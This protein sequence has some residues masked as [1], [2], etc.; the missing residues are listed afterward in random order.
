MQLLCPFGEISCIAKISLFDVAVKCSPRKRY[1]INGS[2]T[3]EHNK[4]NIIMVTPVKYIN[5]IPQGFLR[6]DIS[7]NCIRLPSTKPLYF[8]QWVTKLNQVACSSNSKRVHGII[9]ILQTNR[10]NQSF[11]CQSCM[12]RFNHLFISENKERLILSII[13]SSDSNELSQDHE[14]TKMSMIVMS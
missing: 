8:F 9:Y 13:V 14:R 2:M 4:Q 7:K 6:P 3:Y 10:G 12:C 1:E 5:T 11:E